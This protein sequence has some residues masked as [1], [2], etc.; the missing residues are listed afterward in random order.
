MW[1]SALRLSNIWDPQWF[2][3]VELYHVNVM[4]SQLWQH[5]KKN[6]T[7]YDNI[8]KWSLVEEVKILEGDKQKFESYFKRDISIFSVKNV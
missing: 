4:L 6:W 8:M 2:G 7:H 5:K 3:D 1:Q